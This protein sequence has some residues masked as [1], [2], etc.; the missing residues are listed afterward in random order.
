MMSGEITEKFLNLSPSAKLV[1]TVLEQEEPL[2][3]K[4]IIEKTQLSRPAVRYALTQLNEI[5]KVSEGIHPADARQSIY[6][7]VDC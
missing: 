6:E 5:G 7:T 3:Q 4:Q 2:T 1:F